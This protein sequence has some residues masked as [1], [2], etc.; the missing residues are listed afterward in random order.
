MRTSVLGTVAVLLFGMTITSCQNKCEEQLVGTY[1]DVPEAGW[2]DLTMH[3]GTV[4][5]ALEEDGK[6]HLGA[7]GTVTQGTWEAGDNG[8]WTWIDFH[9]TKDAQ[10]R[11]LGEHLEFIEVM[12]P[13]VFCCPER[14][15]L[16]LKRN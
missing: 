15:T 10:A 16:R 8:D 9:G 13:A 12:V 4:V 6:Y 14:N 7:H 3:P 5:L 11:V 2:N 1:I